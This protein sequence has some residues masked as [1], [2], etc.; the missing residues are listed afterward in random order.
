MSPSTATP[1]RKGRP[2][3]AGATS[4]AAAAAAAR[5][6]AA[7]A[8]DDGVRAK[9]NRVLDTS[10]EV[11]QAPATPETPTAPTKQDSASTVAARPVEPAAMEALE[12]QPE[13]VTAPVAEPS[14]RAASPPPPQAPWSPAPDA[15]PQDAAPTGAD[16]AP[17]AREPEAADAAATAT[18]TDMVVEP[19]P[20]RAAGR[21]GSGPIVTELLERLAQRERQ[22]LALTE[23]N[24][25]LTETS[26][27][28]R[29]QL[30]QLEAAR[31]A[32]DTNADQ[33][34]EEFSRRVQVTEKRLQA[35]QKVCAP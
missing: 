3:A 17:E 1:T 21:G 27:V 28:Y 15:V 11:A 23:E 24:A 14:D 7:S 20:D 31:T 16:T 35:L 32:E 30:E 19:T 29:N 6:P 8:T 4:K 2:G 5:R 10:S 25:S 13:T 18:V 34:A 22:I 33:L 12:P 9:V 26:I